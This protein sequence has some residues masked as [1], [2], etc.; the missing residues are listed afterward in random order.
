MNPTSKS[1]LKKCGQALAIVALLGLLAA[2]LIQWRLREPADT[3][4]RPEVPPLHTSSFTVSATNTVPVELTSHFNA[5]LDQQWN[6]TSYPGDDLAELPTGP[7]E[8][9]GVRLDI[10]GVIQ[11]QGKEWQRRG[12]RYPE[13]VAGIPIQ[14]SCHYLYVLHADGG[15]RA[16]TG[17]TVASLVLHYGD[18]TTAAIPIQ[19]DVH[20]KD[21]WTHNQPPPSDPDTVVAWT[22][23]NQAT[24]RMGNSNRLYLTRFD[25][26][27]PKK[28]I[29]TL[30]YVSAMEA[31]GPFMVALT[32]E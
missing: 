21:W 10:R 1:L 15:A 28:Q 8:F 4:D 13:Q 6:R 18:G 5:R 7:Q 27:Q 9:H 31:P 29:E 23:K 24:A 22:G 12:L 17:A 19:H 26:P 11:L 25:N 16:P 32:V 2:L 20:V 3:E 14:R 30:D